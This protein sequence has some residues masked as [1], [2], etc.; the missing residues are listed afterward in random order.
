MAET[1]YNKKQV[2]FKKK[3][4]NTREESKKCDIFLWAEG[5]D[6]RLSFDCAMMARKSRM[7]LRHETFRAI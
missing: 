1:N 4:V 2:F 5:G 7:T 6:V 3:T